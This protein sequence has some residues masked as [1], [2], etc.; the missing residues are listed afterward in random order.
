M[1]W[2]RVREDLL[3]GRPV[4][5]YDLEG[6][7][8]ETDM[9]LYAGSIDH[10]SIYMLRREA[11]GLI[12][13]VT[14]EQVARELGL[15]FLSDLLTQ[16]PLYRDLASK[17]LRYGDQPPYT[18]YV[19]HIKVR[20]G[21]SDRDRALTIRELDKI[22]GLIE[23][24]DAKLA[25]EIFYREFVAPGH[26]PIL[27]GRDISLRRGHTELSLLIAKRTGL[28][29][30]MVIAEMLVEGDSMSKDEAIKYAGERGFIFIEGI[31]LLREE[32]LK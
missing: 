4:L 6:R 5:L 23:R 28:R 7:E 20:T 19:N 17:R 2:S 24:G 13:Y 15:V 25:R 27:I 32:G 30:S 26:V 21:I 11:G 10:R 18:L 29:P 12:C 16:H 14:S 3:S 22:V 31:D 8:E 1:D 9:V